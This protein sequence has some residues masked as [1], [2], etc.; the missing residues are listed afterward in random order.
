MTNFLKIV[1][2]NFSDAEMLGA[3]KPLNQCRWI[4]F[5]GKKMISVPEGQNI[6]GLIVFHRLE[7]HDTHYDLQFL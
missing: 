7:G 6:S 4:K 1:T 3:I 5:V 2:A